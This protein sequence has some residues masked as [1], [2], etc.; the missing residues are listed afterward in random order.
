[1]E[2]AREAITDESAAEKVELVT[3]MSM[4]EAELDKSISGLTSEISK[5]TAT[6]KKM[7]SIHSTVSEQAA[8]E[9]VCY[10][11]V[12]IIILPYYLLLYST[13]MRKF[14]CNIISYH[15]SGMVSFSILCFIVFHITDTKCCRRIDRIGI[16]MVYQALSKRIHFTMKSI[17]ASSLI[18]MVVYRKKA[19]NIPC[20]ILKS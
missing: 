15:M 4:S 18:Y 1:M 9:E 10:S 16:Q 11:S 12:F 19:I 13:V 3:M 20:K 14:P 17:V 8:E 7:K 6:L 2:Y 5:M